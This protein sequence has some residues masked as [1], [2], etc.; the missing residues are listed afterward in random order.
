VWEEEE[1]EWI[2]LYS[3]NY[4]H[5]A[6]MLLYLVDVVITIIIQ[7]TYQELLVAIVTQ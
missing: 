6:Q 1:E 2:Y 5:L 4:G 3:N 7:A